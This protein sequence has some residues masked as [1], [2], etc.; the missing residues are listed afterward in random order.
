MTL[1]RPS[2]RGTAQELIEATEIWERDVYLRRGR[3]FRRRCRAVAFCGVDH[4]QRSGPNHWLGA[5]ELIA[6]T[7]FDRL[8]D[9][10]NRVLVHEL[11]RLHESARA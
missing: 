8:S 10:G 2:T 3:H 6:L 11:Q 9:A 1:T 7:G 5:V 4:G